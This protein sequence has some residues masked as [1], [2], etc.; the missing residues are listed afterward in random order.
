MS[1]LAH[2]SRSPFDSIRHIDERGNEFWYARELMPL[3]EYSNWQ[4]FCVVIVKAQKACE[5]TNNQVLDH[6]T[7]ADKMVPVGSGANRQIQDYRFSRYGCYLVAMNGDPRKSAIAQAQSYFATKTH[8]AETANLVAVQQ[9]QQQLPSVQQTL[10]DVDFLVGWIAK[11]DSELNLLEQ[12]KYDT[13]ANIHPQYRLLLEAAK[14]V[15]STEA[16]HD[17]VGMTATQIGDKLDPRMSAVKLNRVLEE[18]GLQ[19]R[20]FSGKK[21]A[22]QLSESGKEH[23]FVYFATNDDKWSGD[24]IRWQDSVIAEIQD[25]FDCTVV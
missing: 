24:Q 16:I 8:E 2:N 23:G 19:Y 9:F 3:L 15:R 20:D 13:V 12:A 22:W 14:K 7:D 21:P 1:N 10:A 11:T 18:M 25:Y 6:F 4:N 17:A 5:N